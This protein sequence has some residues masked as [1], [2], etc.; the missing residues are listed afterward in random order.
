MSSFNMTV[1]G[2]YCVCCNSHIMWTKAHAIYSPNLSR[3]ITP[4]FS[5]HWGQRS[6]TSSTPMS[7]S[8]LAHQ[9]RQ[10]LLCPA[11]SVIAD[12]AQA[13]LPWEIQ[14]RKRWSLLLMKNRKRVVS[15]QRHVTFNKSSSSLRPPQWVRFSYMKQ[16]T[17]IPRYTCPD[18]TCPM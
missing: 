14:S 8:P 2:I 13:Q 10:L 7:V 6:L 17:V 5:L 15:C 3:S 1:F 18:Q 9:Q 16:Y 12:S 4:S 11:V